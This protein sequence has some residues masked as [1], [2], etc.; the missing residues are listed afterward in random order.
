MMSFQVGRIPRSA[1][2]QYHPVDPGPVFQ[3]PTST[4][5]FLIV[6]VPIMLVLALVFAR[7]STIPDLGAACSVP[8]SCPA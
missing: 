8:S 7:C 1:A 3:R 5:I 2:C 6:Q 4:F